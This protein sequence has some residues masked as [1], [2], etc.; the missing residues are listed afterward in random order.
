MEKKAPRI[1]FYLSFLS[2]AF[3]LLF[4]GY[5]A[6]FGLSFFRMCYGWDGF[7]VGIMSGTLILCFIP[8]LPACLVYEICYLLRCK[9]SMVQKIPL[10][11]YII[12]ASVAYVIIVLTAFVSFL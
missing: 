1:L 2:W 4:G 3:I 5:G 11:K 8:I 7:F 9:V 10:K 6:V 12:G